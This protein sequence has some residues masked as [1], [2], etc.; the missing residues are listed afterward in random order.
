MTRYTIFTPKG[1]FFILGDG[2]TTQPVP[3]STEVMQVNI[4]RRSDEVKDGMPV[5]LVP[6]AS[7]MRALAVYPDGEA[8]YTEGV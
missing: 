6:I 2:F 3:N 1:F 4:L 8:A 7:F 5:G